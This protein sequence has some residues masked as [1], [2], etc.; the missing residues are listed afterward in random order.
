M[1][2]RYCPHHATSAN[3]YDGAAGKTPGRVSSSLFVPDH[4]LEYPFRDSPRGQLAKRNGVARLHVYR[5]LSGG[6]GVARVGEERKDVG[7]CNLCAPSNSLGNIKNA[8][9]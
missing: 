7:D 3:V 4:I 6:C 1:A 8:T 9:A 5:R 2:L